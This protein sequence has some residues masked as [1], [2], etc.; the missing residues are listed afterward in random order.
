MNYIT[1]IT[2]ANNT[3]KMG[4]N[5]ASF[6]LCC[7][8]CQCIGKFFVCQSF[9]D[10]SLVGSDEDV[11]MEP[12]TDMSVQ[13]NRGR[14]GRARGQQMRRVSHR[15]GR[16]GGL[17]NV[18]VLCLS[19]DDARRVEKLQKIELQMNRYYIVFETFLPEISIA[20]TTTSFVLVGSY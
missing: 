7:I 20:T 11:F 8:I 17:S 2:N 4:V 9:H 13:A 15:G 6:R 3:Y 16:R 19:L 5:P 12:S 1:T 14:R 18:G 10:E